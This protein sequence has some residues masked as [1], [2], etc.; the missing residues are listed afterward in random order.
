MLMD[1]EDTGLNKSLTAELFNKRN[2]MVVILVT[3]SAEIDHINRMLKDKILRTSIGTRIVEITRDRIALNNG[4]KV[5]FVIA[6]QAQ[7]GT[8]GMTISLLLFSSS[9][10]YNVRQEI[11]RD[12]IHQVVGGS[13]N[14]GTL[15]I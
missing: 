12:L 1:I 8:I 13:V 5:F 2:I 4:N 3:V 9:I 15:Q 14:I 11:K 7:I 10:E 6:N